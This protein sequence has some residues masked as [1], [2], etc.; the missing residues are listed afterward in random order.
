LFI[1]TNINKFKQVMAD[2]DNQGIEIG[3]MEEPVVSED[4]VDNHLVDRVLGNLVDILEAE[5]DNL[6]E[7]GSSEVVQVVDWVHY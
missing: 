6:V 3:L 5:A 4:M 7:E 2:T 1:I